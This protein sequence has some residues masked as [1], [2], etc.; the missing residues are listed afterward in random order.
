MPAVRVDGEQVRPLD[1]DAAEHERRRDVALVP[2]QMRLEHLQGRGDARGAARREAVQR[3]RGR[4]HAR[5]VFGVGRGARA[6]AVDVRGDKV[7]L[8]AVLV[9][10]GGARGRA[11]VGPEDDAVL[12]VAAAEEEEGEVERG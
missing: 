3:E 10:D 2:E 5:R 7:D 6:A 9:G 1:V 8:L 12:V 11:R 4:D